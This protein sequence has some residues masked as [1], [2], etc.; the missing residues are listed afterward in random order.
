MRGVDRAL[1]NLP[2]LKVGDEIPEG[3]DS[4]IPDAALAESTRIIADLILLSGS[5]SAVVMNR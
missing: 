5:G 2:P 4:V 3:K 1:K